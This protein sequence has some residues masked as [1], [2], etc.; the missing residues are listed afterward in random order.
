MEK[1]F[2]YIVEDLAAIKRQ[3]YIQARFN[4]RLILFGLLAIA[5]ADIYTCKLHNKYE[6]LSAE[7]KEIKQS[8]GE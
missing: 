6:Q 8:K 5:V 3:Q 7:L 1:V 4:R 2:D